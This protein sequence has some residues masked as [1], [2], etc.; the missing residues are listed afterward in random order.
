MLDTIAGNR[1][2]DIA[3]QFLRSKVGKR[4]GESF[5]EATS[6]HHNELYAKLISTRHNAK[7][8][9]LNAIMAKLLTAI[10]GLSANT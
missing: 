6:E 5:V 2:G 3:L 4:S 10:A 7:F 8:R 9:V 1:F